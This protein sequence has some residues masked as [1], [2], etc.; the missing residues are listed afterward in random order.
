MELHGKNLIGFGVS[1]QGKPVLHGYDPKAGKPLTPGFAEATSEEIGRACELAVN[2]FDTLRAEQPERIAVLLEKIASNIEALGDTLIDRASTE[3]GLPRERITG[4]RGRTV[5]QLRLFASLVR[6]GS[7]VDARIDTAKPDRQ[8]LP[9]P[10]VRRML[11]PIG[12]IRFGV[13]AIFLS[14]FPLLGATR[15]LPL[16]PKILLSS[17]RIRHIPEHRN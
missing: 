4:E 2:A 10:D 16:H 9:K 6:E 8:P 14:R 1:A 3:S 17:K 15:P 12:P 7:W 11:I 13:R 5:G